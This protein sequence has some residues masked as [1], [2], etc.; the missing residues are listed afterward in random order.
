M[1]RFNAAS[2]SDAD[3][4]VAAAIDQI[5][6]GPSAQGHQPP[7]LP[8]MLAPDLFLS[9]LAD[10]RD[11]GRLCALGITHVLN[12]AGGPEFDAERSARPA[13]TPNRIA[14]LDLPAED[15]RTYPLMEQH[16]RESLRFRRAC[17]DCH[18]KL[19]VH[20][21]AGINRSGAI[22]IAI[23]FSE[24]AVDGGLMG[25]VRHVHSIR[26]P[27]CT[28]RGFQMQLAKWA[29]E[30]DESAGS[31]GIVEQGRGLCSDPG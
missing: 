28:N 19:L 27:V 24:V 6:Q 15:H 20:C 26:G 11:A 2:V 5:V 13:N 30:H 7:S 18:G 29:R 25:C 8:C 16:A 4:E 1:L 23:L 22:A 14:Y 9:G 12:L 3:K 10:A 31:G 21:Q 17:R